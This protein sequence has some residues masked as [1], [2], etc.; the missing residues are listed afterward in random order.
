MY[1]N[2]LENG[3]IPD[4]DTISLEYLSLEYLPVQAR[5]PTENGKNQSPVNTNKSSQSP[6]FGAQSNDT[7]QSPSFRAQSSEESP[8]V[9][10]NT[11][12]PVVVEPVNIQIN[13]NENQSWLINYKDFYQ[14]NINMNGK[15]NEAPYFT[16]HSDLMNTFTDV[17][18]SLIVLEGYIMALV[19]TLDYI[20]VF[21]SHARN[22]F[23]MLDPNGT[24]V[25]MKCANISQL[26]Q[27]LRSLSLE[28]NNELFEIVPVEFQVNMNNLQAGPEKSDI[29]WV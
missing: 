26:E 11:D 14:G 20:Y 3:D 18:H 2:A 16:L 8:I 9:V 6:S 24:A 25:V 23:G 28:L 5:W 15:E 27:H 12:L 21:D 7:D 1:L 10:N 22:S 19:N 4:A 13:K 29:T 17:S